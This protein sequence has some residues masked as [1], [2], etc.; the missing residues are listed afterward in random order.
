MDFIKRYPTL[1]A[2]IINIIL[3]VAIIILLSTK[4]KECFEN[5]ENFDIKAGSETACNNMLETNITWFESAITKIDTLSNI[6]TTLYDK[7]DQYKT[8]YNTR[9]ITKNTTNTYAKDLMLKI[10]DKVRNNG[11]QVSADI[12]YKYQLIQDYFSFVKPDDDFIIY[13]NANKKDKVPASLLISKQLV[14]PGCEHCYLCKN[15]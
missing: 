2:V 8:L 4:N 13:Y 3:C 14:L 1:I 5:I 10:Y 6:K 7:L 11:K 15:L 12:L 9:C